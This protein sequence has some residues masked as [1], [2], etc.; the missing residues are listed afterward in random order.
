MGGAPEQQQQQPPQ[1]PQQYQQQQQPRTNAFR[2]APEQHQQQYQHNHQ[3]SYGSSLHSGQ[4]YSSPADR[5]LHQPETHHAYGGMGAAAAAS[6]QAA[7]MSGYYDGF[8]GSYDASNNDMLK[9]AAVQHQHQHHQHHHHQQQ[10]MDMDDDYD[11][12]GRFWRGK[13]G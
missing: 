12:E 11:K 3:G 7:R 6:Q 5:P 4:P 8:S 10:R 2:G 9:G 1:Q 13:G